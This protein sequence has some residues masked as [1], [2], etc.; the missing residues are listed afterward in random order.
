MTQTEFIKKV[1][2]DEI[3]DILLNHKFLSFGLI[4]TGIELLGTCIESPKNSFY[5]QGESGNRFRLAIDQLFPS[6]YKRYNNLKN[7]NNFNC[8]LYIELRCG[9]NHSL[10]PKSKIALTERKFNHK[11]LS[12]SGDK[13]LLVAE[14]F[15]EDF[16][17]A[18][19]QVIQKI[20]NGEIK[21]RFSLNLI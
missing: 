9:M 10:L 15:F 18:C 14:D 12:S 20:D 1:L 11:N 17:N 3:G 4:A 2:I 8:D 13:L 19:N 21:E 16:R 6:E 5:I 7:V